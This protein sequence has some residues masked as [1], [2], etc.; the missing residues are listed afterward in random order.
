[1]AL[2]PLKGSPFCRLHV[3]QLYSRTSLAGSR[4]NPRIDSTT[5][6]SDTPATNANRGYRRS[7]GGLEPDGFSSRDE[8]FIPWEGPPPGEI[9]AFVKQARG[10]EP[11]VA[12]RAAQRAIPT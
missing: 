1:M 10:K 7:L 5:P 3:R 11:C 6:R 4:A 2:T 8:L 12:F 9:R